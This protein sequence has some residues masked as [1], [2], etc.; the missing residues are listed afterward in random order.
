MI[1]IHFTTLLHFAAITPALNAAGIARLG[2][3]PP[4][5]S[6]LAT[7]VIPRDMSEAHQ[8][9]AIPPL[10]NHDLIW[11]RLKSLHACLVS[12]QLLSIGM[13]FFPISHA[14]SQPDCFPSSW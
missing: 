6:T 14:F 9:A 4:R 13:R 8:S 1:I 11:P 10:S 5:V 3:A 7:A 12:I 2:V